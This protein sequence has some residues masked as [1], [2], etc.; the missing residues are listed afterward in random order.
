MC[1]ITNFLAAI[2]SHVNKVFA[3]SC[4]RGGGTT[5]QPAGGDNILHVPPSRLSVCQWG[6]SDMHQLFWWHMSKERKGPGRFKEVEISSENMIY[7]D[8][9][10]S[11]SSPPKRLPSL[12]PEIPWSSPF[13]PVACHCCFLTG[14]RVVLS[15]GWL[16]SSHSICVSWQGGHLY[17]IS[18]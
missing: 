13:L 1:G 3:E 12:Q 5:G 17:H 9:P 11:I 15:S 18:V 4:D 14:T 10:L 16:C 6:F 8:L 2:H 7:P